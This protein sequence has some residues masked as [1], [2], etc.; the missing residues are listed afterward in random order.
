MLYPQHRPLETLKYGDFSSRLHDKAIEQRIPLE[1]SIELTHRCN[2]SC[3][4]CYVNKSANDEHE[5]SKELKTEQ[6][7]KII[8]EITEAGCLW[9]LI[10]GGEP[11]LREDFLDI[12]LYAKKHGLLITVFTNGVLLNENIASFFAKH[13]PFSIGITLYG[14]SEQTYKAVTGSASAL[15][16]AHRAIDLLLKYNIF[17]ELR[18]TL[19]TAN[20]C[21][22]DSLKRW[23]KK[24]RLNFKYDLYLN[25][26]IDGEKTPLAVRL[27]PQQAVCLDLKDRKRKNQWLKL[28]AKGPDKTDT[29]FIIPCGAGVHGFHIDPFGNLSLCMMVRNPSVS[30]TQCGFSEGWKNFLYH[31]RMNKRTK[32]MLCD[33]C[34]IHML[35]DQCPGWA[36]ME[37]NDPETVVEYLCS[38]AQL[39]YDKLVLNKKR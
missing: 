23:A 18:T 8:D 2:L 36:A 21:D 7:Y 24:K 14:N 25:P 15:H 30:L 39:R 12:Y 26:R 16:K 9:L 27:S 22:L 37:N 28:L 10:T 3:V 34:K 5:I 31:A 6:W 20:T 4:H 38:V 17:T 11:L 29:E 32:N 33:N 19:S 1:G 35:C 13:K